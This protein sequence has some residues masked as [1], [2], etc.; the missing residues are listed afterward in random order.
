MIGLLTAP[1][2][3]AYQSLQH[4]LGIISPTT[5]RVVQWPWE[6]TRPIDMGEVMQAAESFRRGGD[7]RCLFCGEEPAHCTANHSEAS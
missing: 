3:W 5:G 2:R 7:G 4:V 1:L 6:K